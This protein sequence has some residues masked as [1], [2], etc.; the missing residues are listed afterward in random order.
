MDA[1]AVAS[2]G[3]VWASSVARLKL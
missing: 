2:P 3:V 1:E